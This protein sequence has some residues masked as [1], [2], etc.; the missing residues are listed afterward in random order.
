MQWWPWFYFDGRNKWSMM[1]EWWSKV[2]ESSS[3]LEVAPFF[4]SCLNLSW[5]SSSFTDDNHHRDYES[6][7]GGG[8]GD[9]NLMSDNSSPMHVTVNPPVIGPSPS[10]VVKMEANQKAKKKKERQGL[11]GNEMNWNKA[12]FG[13]LLNLSKLM[14]GKGNEASWTSWRNGW[15]Y[16]QPFHLLSYNFVWFTLEGGCKMAVKGLPGTNFF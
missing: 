3:H 13:E 2:S 8:G 15:N 5:H 14:K 9:D 12:L 6:D 10:S 7:D 16:I 11:L 1:L 4:L